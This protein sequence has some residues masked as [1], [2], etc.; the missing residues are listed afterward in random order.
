[1]KEVTKLSL[2]DAEREL[3]NYV[4]L[5]D[6]DDIAPYDWLIN[7]DCSK[8]DTEGS[9]IDDISFFSNHYYRKITNFKICDVFGIHL[10]SFFIDEHDPSHYFL[11]LGELLPHNNND[12][13]N[14]A[15]SSIKVKIPI[16]DW[17]FTFGLSSQDKNNKCYDAIQQ[18]I[19]ENHLLEEGYWVEDYLFTRYHLVFPCLN[20][21]R[22]IYDFCLKQASFAFYPV[23]APFGRCIHRLV[24]YS[25]CDFE[26]KFLNPVYHL[27]RLDY[28]Y[29]PICAKGRILNSTNQLY[30]KVFFP[31][32][33]YE[34]SFGFPE[35]T[36]FEK[37]KKE[38]INRGIFVHH[39]NGTENLWFKLEKPLKDYNDQKVLPDYVD[40]CNK[41]IC[42]YMRST[43]FYCAPYQKITDFQLATYDGNGIERGFPQMNEN[44]TG[45][46]SL[47][48]AS[49]NAVSSDPY[50]PLLALSGK[51]FTK[52]ENIYVR[53][54]VQNYVFDSG[55]R[56]Q[57]EVTVYMFSPS[58]SIHYR[59]YPSAESCISGFNII[60]NDYDWPSEE[61]S[62]EIWRRI[63]DYSLKDSEGKFTSLLFKTDNTIHTLT[64][65]LLPS[66]EYARENLPLLP[67]QLYSDGYS[68]DF[69]RSIDDNARGLWM[70]EIHSVWFKI[71]D[72]PAT[73]YEEPG[74]A[75]LLNTTKFLQFHDTLRYYK[76]NDGKNTSS[77][78]SEGFCYVDDEGLF[79][80]DY[81][82]K[83]L[84]L[85]S[86]K[87]FDIKFVAENKEFVKSNL[88]VVINFSS[89]R[90]F[91]FSLKTL[92][93]TIIPFFLF[94]SAHSCSFSVV[95]IF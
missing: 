26:G 50:L 41:M 70:R 17:F 49:P 31:F 78:P 29:T 62:I 27:S 24:D 89:S 36:D 16:T 12:E 90:K 75:A 64:G 60:L 61:G 44:Q 66:P 13:N 42:D 46:I 92:D 77:D 45:F 23:Q 76:H 84:Y 1:M 48:I 54:F 10:K 65:N 93:G 58:E 79:I 25:I 28:D 30:L 68:I 81:S 35:S 8:N 91:Y 7:E 43:K 37:E 67:I 11:L 3:E 34:I 80:C 82:I 59:L 83:E 72:P 57:D 87:N 94:S 6:I 88:G 14:S 9:E 52:V 39:L 19:Q 71:I 15:F 38:D 73:G 32:L 18:S 5:E 53:S 33:R 20:E 56:D 51:L 69:G 47:S 21:Y 86:N 2:E 55:R 74:A 95:F 4:F 85:K 22:E 63:K 40:P